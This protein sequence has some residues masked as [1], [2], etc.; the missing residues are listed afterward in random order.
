[1]ANPK[2]QYATFTK[3]QG[4]WAIRC[5]L[6]TTAGSQITTR[7]AGGEVK[8]VKVVKV[9]AHNGDSVICSFED[10]EKATPTRRGATPSTRTTTSRSRAK[11]EGTLKGDFDTVA[12]GERQEEIGR[13]VFVKRAGERVPAVIVGWKTEYVREDGLSFG[14][15]DDSGWFTVTYYR[16][17]TP[18][19]S[20]Q[21][22]AQDAAKKAELE[23][24][25]TEAKEAEEA[26]QK[27]ARAP[28]E[29][30]VSCDMVR[31]P[32]GKREEVGRY[33]KFPNVTITKITTEDGTIVYQQ[34]SYAFDDFRSVIYATPEV[35]NQ[36]RENLVAEHPDTYTKKVAEEFLAKYRGCVGTDFYEWLVSRS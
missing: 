12:R 25:A 16:K 33:G 18:E 23:R 31:E 4:Q 6:G 24:K 14:Y 29:G 35:I 36:L 19:E 2:V 17:A 9:L 34:C 10:L 8:A 13:S 5:P 3:Y 7:K 1:M 20:A 30:L 28:L 15:P 26:A 11:S 27:A 22:T 21:L 32:Q